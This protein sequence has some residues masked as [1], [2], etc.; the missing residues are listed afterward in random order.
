MAGDYYTLIFVPHAKARFR[1]VQVPVKLA[2]IFLR[3]AIIGAVCFV[4]A[5]VYI[6]YMGWELYSLRQM[7]QKHVRLVAQVQEYESQTTALK[8][9]LTNLESVVRKL[10]VMAGIEKVLPDSNV[11]GVGGLSTK[12]THAPS[13]DAAILQEMQKTAVDLESRSQQLRIRQSQRSVH[14]PARFSPGDRY[15]DAAGDEDRGSG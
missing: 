5:L 15:L 2:K 8:S 1:K 9:Q 4:G 3:T 7:R 13:L 10:G 12:E 14:R 6:A 11:G